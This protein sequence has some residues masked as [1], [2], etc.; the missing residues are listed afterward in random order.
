MAITDPSGEIIIPSYNRIS[1]L[2]ETVRTIRTL[3]P[4]LPICLGLQG[5]MPSEPWSSELARDPYLRIE[6]RDAPSTTAT[7]NRCV[8]TSSADIIMFLDDDAIPHFG[9][10]ESHMAAFAADADLCYTSGREVRSSKGKSSFLE[11]N[12]ILV[13]W[14]CGL[15]LSSSN[16][17]RG[18]IIG[19][20]N[21]IGFI[22]GNF[23]Q[24]GTCLINTPRACNMAVKR[25]AFLRFDGFKESYRGNAWGFEADFGLRLAKKGMFGR[26][27]GD[28]IVVHHEVATGGSR[29]SAKRQWY[30]DYLHNH[31]ILIGNL[32]PLAWIGSLPRLANK[33]IW[34]LA[35]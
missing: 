22:F 33:C 35:K 4:R 28:A 14:C 31:K 19:W 16:K 29:D 11:W 18:R 21:K 8:R 30:K 20:T 5:E 17:I 26:Y 15:F 34:L 12:R 10:F 27:V 6:K 1:V 7:M 24:P 25:E 2:Q 23:D 13:E 3:Y 9:W 32:G